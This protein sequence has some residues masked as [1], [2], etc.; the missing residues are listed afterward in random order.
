MFNQ[1]NGVK[2][3]VEVKFLEMVRDMKNR[4]LAQAK[5]NEPF[6]KIVDIQRYEIKNR[7]QLFIILKDF[8][9]IREREKA[10]I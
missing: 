2:T 6:K 10:M 3:K 1:V 5:L 7:N 4:E 9:V 8:S